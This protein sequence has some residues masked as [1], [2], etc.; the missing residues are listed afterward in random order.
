M[1]LPRLRLTKL[2]SAALVGVV[3]LSTLV[4]PSLL[5]AD[6]GGSAARA[7]VVIEINLFQHALS[8]YGRWIDSPRYGQ[9]WYPVGMHSGWRPY[10]DDG[11]WAYSDDDGW[12]WVSDL[13]WGWAPF[14]YGRWAFDPYYGWIWVPGARLGPGLGHLPPGQR[15][16]RLGAAAAGSPLGSSAMGIVAVAVSTSP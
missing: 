7:E 8:P 2:A 3:V 10:Y 11:H 6:M 15:L 9:V 16:H 12:I 13:P 4:G 1:H 14:H 5:P